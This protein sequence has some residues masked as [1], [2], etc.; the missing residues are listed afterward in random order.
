MLF[1]TSTLYFSYSYLKKKK[2]NLYE[3][4]GNDIKY[5]WEQNI[6]TE[7]PLSIYTNLVENVFVNAHGPLLLEQRLTDLPSE[8]VIAL[9]LTIDIHSLLW[10]TIIRLSHFGRFSPYNRAF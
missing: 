7:I 1:Y 6:D 9:K 3:K 8:Y 4:A 5:R 2:K 10:S